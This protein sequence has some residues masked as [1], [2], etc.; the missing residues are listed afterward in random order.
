MT[1]MH[2]GRQKRS[3]E[4]SSTQVCNDKKYPTVTLTFKDHSRLLFG[5]FT[6][7]AAAVGLKLTKQRSPDTLIYL[8][9]KLLQQGLN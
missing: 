9:I 6:L 8:C 3:V 1:Q 2:H 4:I 5:L 7:T